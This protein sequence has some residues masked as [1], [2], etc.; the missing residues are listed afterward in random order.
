MPTVI[1][2]PCRADETPAA[3]RLVVVRAISQRGTFAPTSLRWRSLMRNV[4][5]VLFLALALVVL[6]SFW[7]SADGRMVPPVRLTTEPDAVQSCEFLG[8]VDDDEIKD[9]RKKI[10]R[11]GGDTGLLS[12]SD[13][14]TVYAKVFRCPAA[15]D[16]P[17]RAAGPAPVLSTSPAPQP[18]T[19]SGTFGG[20]S[21][22]TPKGSTGR[23]T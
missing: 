1:K 17:S 20:Q 16:A 2:R 5:A 19:L 3:R 9:L 10:I 7:V 18:A 11:A 6:S 14:N 12:F 15:Q 13:G 8:T 22:A 4:T 23:R 21:R